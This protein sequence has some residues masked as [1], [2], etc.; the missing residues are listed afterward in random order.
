MENVC[1]REENNKEIEKEKDEKELRAEKVRKQT[2]KGWL[3][4]KLVAILVLAMGLVVMTVCIERGESFSLLLVDLRTRFVDNA[5]FPYA[6]RNKLIVLAAVF[7]LLIVVALFTQ[8]FWWKLKLGKWEV[9]VS[10]QAACFRW[11][12]NLCL[13]VVAAAFVVQGVRFTHPTV[14]AAW[15]EWDGDALIAHAG[16]GIEEQ[17]YTNSK[18]A[19]ISSYEAGMRTI[20]IDFV[21]TSDDKLVCCHDWKKQMCSDYEAEY[22]YS[23]EEFLN[24]RIYDRFT[25]M[26]LETLMEL[27]KIYDDVLIVTDTKDRKIELVQ[28]EFQ[29]LVDTAKM[30]G[31]PELLDRFVVQI[32]DY[33]MYDAVEAIYSFPSYVL[34]L[35]RLGGVDEESFREHCRFLRNRDINSITMRQSWFQPEFKEI[36]DTYGI[37]IYVHTVN[38]ADTVEEM[39]AWGVRG[40]YTDYVTPDM[41]P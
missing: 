33:E 23:E 37:D 2:G 8:D 29:I 36:A 20:E 18:E 5:L 40:F 22:V 19:F 38:N 15:K 12:W 35:Y 3:I 31:A 27:M 1:Q 21:L 26:S 9:V 7:L 17:N 14:R 41:I 32:Y 39:Q 16:G 30:V 13:I 6:F 34:T 28:K 4:A 10:P 25:P 11:G 24:I